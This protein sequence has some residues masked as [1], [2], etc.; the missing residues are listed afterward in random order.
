MKFLS[1]AD[2]RRLLHNKYVAVLGDFIQR[3][4]NN[5]PVKILQTVYF[6]TEKQL[7]GRVRH[8]RTDHH[9]VRFYF[10]TRVSS[11]YIESMLANFQHGPQTDVVIINLCI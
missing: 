9:L 6:R 2:V 7:N 5:D 3:S 1:S 8:Y 10:L 4:V 11:E